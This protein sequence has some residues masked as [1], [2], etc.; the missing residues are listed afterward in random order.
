MDDIKDENDIG[1]L[2]VI[3][4]KQILKANFIDYRGCCE[5]RELMDKVIMLYNSQKK[6]QLNCHDLICSVLYNVLSF[7]FNPPD[8][9]IV[10]KRSVHYAA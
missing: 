10:I 9:C 7:V 4:L 5:K 2:S 6:G 3:E 1:N 8:C